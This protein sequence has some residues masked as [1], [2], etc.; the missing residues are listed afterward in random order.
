MSKIAFVLPGQG[1]QSVGMLAAAGSEWQVVRATFDAAS[2]AVGVDLWRLSQ[3]GPE[4]ELNRTANTQPALLAAGVAL[5]R[6][7]RELG[8]VRPDYLAGHSLG[9]YT[10]LVCAGAVSLADAARLVAARGRYMQEAVA[11]GEGA[12]AAIIGLDDETVEALC[13]AASAS[14]GV[15]SAANFNA[16]G[17]VVIAGDSAAVERALATAREQGAR[18]V[19]PLSVS[20]PS[21]CALMKPAAERLRAAL[22]KVEIAEPELPIVHNVDVVP[23][24]EPATI[25]QALEAQLHRPVRWTG[26]VSWLVEAGVSR[27]AECGP[28]RVLSGLV[29]RGARDTEIAAL[30]DPETLQSR[31]TAWSEA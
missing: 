11:E 17:Q 18:R 24:P 5:W 30:E 9:E 2:E 4:A 15:V 29:K 14:G 28:G 6:V 12:M 1:S 8:G 27:F 19:M 3:A 23:H 13:E 20:V 16:R 21:H 7:W 31:V 22:A 25:R 26:T 10:A